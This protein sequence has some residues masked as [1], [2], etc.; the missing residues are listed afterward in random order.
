MQF[1]ETCFLS[2]LVFTYFKCLHFSHSSIVEFGRGVYNQSVS[3]GNTRHIC[4]SL[5]VTT[6][7]L[8][9]SKIFSFDG[10]TNIMLKWILCGSEGTYDDFI[11]LMFK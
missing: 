3:P 1:F 6:T 2:K 8:M 7:D 4:T 5:V 9:L 11:C 10:L